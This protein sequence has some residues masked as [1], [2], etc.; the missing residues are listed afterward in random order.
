[1]SAFA[2]ALG[3]LE[4]VDD[5]SYHLTVWTPLALPALTLVK[6]HLRVG[7][8]VIVDNVISSA[9]GYK[10]LFEY[11][12]DPKNGF[13]TTTRPIRGWVARGCLCGKRQ[14]M[15]GMRHSTVLSTYYAKERGGA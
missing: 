6:P 14:R 9:S 1:M 2:E 11:L 4:S 13:R 10:D 7:A 5:L 15:S 3:T 12:D 8:L